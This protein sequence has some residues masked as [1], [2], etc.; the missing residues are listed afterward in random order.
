MANPEASIKYYRATPIVFKELSGINTDLSDILE[1]GDNFVKFSSGLL[2]YYDR[3][4][5][6]KSNM[7]VVNSNGIYNDGVNCTLFYHE[8]PFISNPKVF[9]SNLASYCRWEWN[10]NHV[11]QTINDFTATPGTN[12]SFIYLSCPMLLP[13]NAKLTEIYLSAFVL[14]IGR[15]K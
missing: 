4:S 13:A 3:V 5:A 14:S 11:S 1:A 10:N 7:N 9:V 12:A 8:M 15:W 6:S 2:V